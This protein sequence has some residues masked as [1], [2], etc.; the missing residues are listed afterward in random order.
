MQISDTLS[1]AEREHLSPW[2]KADTS[3]HNDTCPSFKAVSGHNVYC[4]EPDVDFRE[5]GEG[6]PRFTVYVEMEVVAE[7]ESVIALEEWLNGAAQ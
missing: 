1:K 3:W 7:M 2:I 4:E 6:T 5:G